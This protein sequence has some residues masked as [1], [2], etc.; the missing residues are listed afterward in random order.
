MQG[1]VKKKQLPVKNFFDN[2]WFSKAAYRRRRAECQVH[3]SMWYV[4]VALLQCLQ[5]AK[6]LCL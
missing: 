2:I 4:A 6:L 3:N 5:I 1:C